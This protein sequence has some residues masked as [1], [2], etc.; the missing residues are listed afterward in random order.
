[1]LVKFSGP[2]PEGSPR[3]FASYLKGLI[4]ITMLANARLCRDCSAPN[5]QARWLRL[6]RN[7]GCRP[8]CD[9]DASNNHDE[10]QQRRARDFGVSP[11]DLLQ[12]FLAS[13]G[14]VDDSQ[15][16]ASLQSRNWSSKY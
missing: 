2:I 11:S 4:A 1:M 16:G 3:Q 8:E 15:R 14:E 10:R 5:L 12:L 7:V 6:V 13:L 9:P